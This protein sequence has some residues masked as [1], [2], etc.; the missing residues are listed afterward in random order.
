MKRIL[1]ILYNNMVKQGGI[2]SF[3]IETYRNIDK[4]K[5]QFDFLSLESSNDLRTRNSGHGWE[6]ICFKY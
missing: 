5:V 6:N 2:E 1:H 3:L 4:S